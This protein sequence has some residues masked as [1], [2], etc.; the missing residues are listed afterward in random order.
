[1]GPRMAKLFSIL[2][3]ISVD[4]RFVLIC[5]DI[6]FVLILAYFVQQGIYFFMAMGLLAAVISVVLNIVDARCGGQLNAVG[7]SGPQGSGERP[8]SRSR[9]GPREMTGQVINSSNSAGNDINSSNSGRNSNSSRN[10]GRNSNTGSLNDSLVRPDDIMV[11]RYNGESESHRH[12]SEAKSEPAG[13]RRDRMK[14][15]LLDKR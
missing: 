15:G 14:E 1:M 4:I 3:C 7:E 6:R 2:R 10:S 13:T 9:P 12:K 8:S 11:N 5:N